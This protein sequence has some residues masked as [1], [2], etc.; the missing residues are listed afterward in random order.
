MSEEQRNESDVHSNPEM[1]DALK[2]M[3]NCP[4]PI[5]ALSWLSHH[6]P[7]PACIMY[8]RA[9]G[10]LRVILNFLDNFR[11]H[12]TLLYYNVQTTG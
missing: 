6:P 10:D 11:N 4:G 8:L 2:D 12:S 7:A 9:Y 1:R 5:T 3:Y